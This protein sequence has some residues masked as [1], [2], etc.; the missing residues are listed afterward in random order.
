MEAFNNG[1]G[2]RIHF[3]IKFFMGM[4]VAAEKS[5]EPKHVPIFGAADDHR[6]SGAGLEQADP[7]KN[8][9]SH[10]ALAEFSLGNQ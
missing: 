3:G 8:E 7:A 10:D 9:R 1:F 5:G 2:L 4:A 6:S